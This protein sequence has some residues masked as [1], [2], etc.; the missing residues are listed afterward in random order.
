VHR[1]LC[2]GVA[3]EPREAFEVATVRFHVGAEPFPNRPRLVI[4]ERFA[5]GHHG[6]SAH[7]G[8]MHDITPS[9]EVPGVPC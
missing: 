5:I 9:C 3:F 8:S 6:E 2:V 1:N 4:R 7:D